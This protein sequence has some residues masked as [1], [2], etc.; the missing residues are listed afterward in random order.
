MSNVLTEK[1][2]VV[3]NILWGLLRMVVLVGRYLETDFRVEFDPNTKRLNEPD[4]QMENE[5]TKFRVIARNKQDSDVVGLALSWFCP[6]C[7]LTLDEEEWEDTNGKINVR[8]V[9]KTYLNDMDF[10][11]LYKWIMSNYSANQLLVARERWTNNSSTNILGE[12]TLVDKSVEF[13]QHMMKINSSSQSL[14]EFNSQ[15]D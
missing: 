1:E 10:F 8:Y 2:L 14:L 7:D 15:E 4:I 13:Y 3:K 11:S 9:N 12:E 6:H 5:F